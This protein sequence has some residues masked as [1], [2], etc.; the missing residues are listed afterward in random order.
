MKTIFIG[1]DHR[2]LE[3]KNNLVEYLQ[4]KNIRVEDLGAYENNP[5]DDFPDFAK[6]VA[7]AVLQNA[8]SFLGIVICGSGVGVSI[9][10]NRYP[11]IYCGL[12][13]KKEQVQ[14]A[15]A[16]DQMNILALPSDHLSSSE[17]RE[18]VDTFIDTPFDRKPK[19]LRRLKKIDNLEQEI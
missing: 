2:G 8:E 14:S 19:Y 16:H 4:E 10:A 11:G 12:G 17:A 6:P 15:K 13:F 3:L 18:I 9:S 5:E 7:E 1:A